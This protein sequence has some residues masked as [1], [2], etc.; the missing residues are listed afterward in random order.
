MEPRTVN[1]CVASS[2]LVTQHV[3]TAAVVRELM[4]LMIGRRG[5]IVLPF[6]G[7]IS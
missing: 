4:H 1:W 2:A 3:S 7:N 5:S 6:L